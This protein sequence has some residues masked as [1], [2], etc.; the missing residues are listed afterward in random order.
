MSIA[1]TAASGR[2]GHAILRELARQGLARETV[3]VARD[4][5]RVQVPG[6]EARPGDY[7]SVAGMTAALAGIDTAVMISA[8]VAGGSERI[9]LH[10]NVIEA[11]RVAGVR[12]VLFTSVIGNGREMDTL[13]GPTQQVNRQTEADLQASGLEWVIGRNGLYL[14]LDLIQMRKARESGVYSNPA[15]SGRCPYLT[16]DEIAYAFARL[17]TDGRQAGQIYNITSENLTQAEL[18]GLACGIFGLDVRYEVMSDEACITKFRTLMPERGE[19]VAH[20]LTGCFQSIRAGAFDVPSHFREAAGRPPKTVRQ[21]LEGLF[22][23][24]GDGQSGQP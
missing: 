17:A 5:R 3:A 4:P 21:M 22:D 7:G 16:I 9:P 24:H 11:A 15:G 23:A 14:E 20:M 18:L 2:L 1:V 8:P 19:A 13:F 12:R 10:R 6:I